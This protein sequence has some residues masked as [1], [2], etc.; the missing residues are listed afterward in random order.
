MLL[1]IRHDYVRSE[2]TKREREKEN[3][4]FF[5]GNVAQCSEMLNQ[6]KL[7][8]THEDSANRENEFDLTANNRVHLFDSR[9]HFIR[10]VHS[11]LSFIEFFVLVLHTG[12]ITHSV[13]TRCSNR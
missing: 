9:T 11:C 7:R 13:A 1:V 5:L 12:P 3:E 10:F 2:R 4:I 6:M 8:H